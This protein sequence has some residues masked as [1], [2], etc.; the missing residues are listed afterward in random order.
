[1]L[2]KISRR[3]FLAAT[4]GLPALRT[5]GAKPAGHAIGAIVFDAL[6]LFDLRPVQR[7]AEVRFPGNGA[8]L[9]KEWKT[10]QFEYAWLRT[11]THQYVD[12]WRI[13]EDALIAAAGAMKLHL[14]GEDRDALLAHYLD[15]QPWPDVKPGLEL[16]KKAGLKLAVLS[17]FTG[18]MLRHSEL[19][20]LFDHVLSTEIARTYKPAPQAYRLAV[21]ALNVHRDAILFAAS[22]AWDS[23]GAKAFGFPTIWVNRSQSPW[24]ISGPMP[25]YAAENLVGLIDTVGLKKVGD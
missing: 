18:E 21:D 14:D 9:F 7:I 3:N 13:T 5:F 23:A 16:L 20:S 6:V 24:E 11:I 19:T 22:A 12:F 25:D 10:R 1:M 2:S 8:A 15:L 17:N 4:A